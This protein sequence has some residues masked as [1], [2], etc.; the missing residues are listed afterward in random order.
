M[1]VEALIK[2]LST[3]DPE[4]QVILQKDAEGNG[5]SPLRGVD[6]EAVY[7]KESAYS[8]E[9]YSTK[10]P[11]SDHCMEESEWKKL[12]KQK[13]CVVLYPVN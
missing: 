5:Y 4:S 7:V 11:A 6:N 2:I 13:R 1:K 8:G 10:Y 12:L 9:V 3:L